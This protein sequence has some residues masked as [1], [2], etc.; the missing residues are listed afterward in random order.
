MLQIGSVRFKSEAHRDFFIAMVNF[1]GSNSDVYHQALFYLLGLTD[2][3][4]RHCGD[5]YDFDSNGIQLTGLYR[6]WQTGTTT[7]LTRLAFNLFNGWGEEGQEIQSS[8]YYLFDCSLAPYFAEAIKLR[9][10]EFSQ[11]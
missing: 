6:G 4:R 7:R 11:Y 10:P 9:Y 5:I 8:P 3:T 1:L 2:E